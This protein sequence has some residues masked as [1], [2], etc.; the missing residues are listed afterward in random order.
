MIFIQRKNKLRIVLLFFILLSLF[1]GV[2]TISIYKIPFLGFY[3]S[4]IYG[5][6]VNYLDK[7]K[8]VKSS[9][10]GVE[11]DLV[12]IEDLDVLDVRH[13]PEASINL[14]F[15][16]YLDEISQEKNLKL[17][18][19]I[20]NLNSDNAENVL[21][22]INYLLKKH[23]KLKEHFLVETVRPDALKIF[24]ETGFETSY[25]LP[26][27]HLLKADDLKD[28]LSYI[29]KILKTQPELGISTHYKSYP[30]LENQF[31]NTKKYLWVLGGTNI[32]KDFFLIRKLLKDESVKVVLVS[33]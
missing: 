1:V 3:T 33:F 8:Q 11:L 14:S 9:F 25:Y 7:L 5:H 2:S 6:R 21:G 23:N 15:D 10:I 27:L 31:S 17:W 24:N 26:Y 18:L 32:Y 29:N 22:R 30:I 12:Y 16:E 28:T 4:K 20:K 19:D 13:P